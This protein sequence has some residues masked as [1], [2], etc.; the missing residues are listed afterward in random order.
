MPADP[1]HLG[2]FVVSE[3]SATHDP[4][5]PNILVLSTNKPTRTGG[6]TPMRAAQTISALAA[7]HNVYFVGLTSKTELAWQKASSG[8]WSYCVEARII[9]V[10][11]RRSLELEPSST[12]P[13]QTQTRQ[14]VVGPDFD[15]LA[16]FEG[17]RFD[18]YLVQRIYMAPFLEGVLRM[19]ADQRPPCILDL[20][21]YESKTRRR[22]AGVY[23]DSG[24][25][26]L[27]RKELVQETCCRWMEEQYLHL[28]DTI[29][30]CSEGDCEELRRDHPG[31]RVAVMPNT[32]VPPEDPPEQHDRDPFTFVLV[33]TLGWTP[34]QDGAFFFAEKVLPILRERSSRPIRVVFAGRRAP[35][36]RDR[37][38]RLAHLPEV[39]ITGWFDHVRPYYEQAHVAVVPL[40]A[41]GGTRIKILEAFAHNRPVVATTIGAEGLDVEHGEQILI[42]H[43]PEQFAAHCLALMDDPK[44]RR[45]LAQSGRD[46]VLANHTVVQVREAI[47]RT[48]KRIPVSA[49]RSTSATD[50]R[51]DRSA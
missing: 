18:A 48:F 19:P 2:D 22:I 6:G 8:V 38:D 5:K 34:N 44:R 37:M 36:E 9:P 14:A 26:E 45:E 29:W 28:F 13:I 42:A 25:D 3:A 49:G 40:F 46:W 27:A 17:V 23:L 43:D 51:A 47:E 12:F 7:T 32:I 1:N 41:G 33:G 30:M 35:N 20:D 50:E 15:P 39:E 4:R 10:V 21:D 24:Q 16:L 11:N 31:L